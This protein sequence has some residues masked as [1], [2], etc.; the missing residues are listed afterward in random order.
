MT[1]KNLFFFLGGHD[2]EMVFITQ[3]LKR[4]GASLGDYSLI[5]GAKASSY[6]TCFAMLS[7]ME[8]K[9]T[10][11]LVELEV[12]CDLPEG[13]IVIDH[14]GARADEPASILQVLK[15]LGVK[16]TRWHLLAAA[17]DSRWFPGLLGEVAVP[18]IGYLTPPATPEEIEQIR[19]LERVAQGITVEQELEAET[20]VSKQDGHVKD[21]RVIKM[22]HN[23]TSPVGDRLALEAI[24]RGESI[25]QYVVFSDDGEVN[26]SGHGK[27]ATALNEKFPGGWSGGD[28]G[29][30]EGVA[31]WGSSTCSQNEVIRFLLTVA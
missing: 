24:R 28:L 6:K 14:H 30:A 22:S 27:I 31:F 20:A 23:K 29:N 5:W 21:I 15:L 13:T 26:F 2:G 17:N 16:P 18:G 7:Q 10:P 4:A 11:V 12:D 3:A 9:L 8:E 25:P 1:E 19:L